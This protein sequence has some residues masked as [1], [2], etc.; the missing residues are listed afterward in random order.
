MLVLNEKHQTKFDR[1]VGGFIEKYDKL[2]P[3]FVSYF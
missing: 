2:F 1:L 3:E